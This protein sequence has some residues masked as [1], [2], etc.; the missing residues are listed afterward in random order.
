[1]RK[2]SLL[3]IVLAAACGGGDSKKPASSPGPK[4]PKGIAGKPANATPM[5]MRKQA[6][7]GAFT[8]STEQPGDAGDPFFAWQEDVDED[9]TPNSCFSVEDDEN[10]FVYA[11][12]E[13]YADTCDDGSAVTATLFVVVEGDGAGSFG[14]AGSNVCGLGNIVGCE[15]D[16]SG[17][18]TVCGACTAGG[19]ELVCEDADDKDDFDGDG[20]DDT[21]DQDDDNDGI[22]DDDDT[23]D[24]NDGID[25]DDDTDDDNDGVEDSDD[26]IDDDDFDNDGVSDG[27][28]TDDDNDGVDDDEDTDDDGDGVEDSEDT[29]DD[30][31]GVDDDAEGSEG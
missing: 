27:E 22:D 4:D 30:N 21:V 17:E 20:V 2:W 11:W 7:T 23:D 6:G 13:G 10:K 14:L 25:D 12:C 15:F 5:G 24:D 9:G 1:M 26:E 29:D 28:D 19:G 16:A 8:I 3:S 31:D 18:I